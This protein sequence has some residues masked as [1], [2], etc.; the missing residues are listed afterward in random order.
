MY[1]DRPAWA[2]SFQCQKPRV[3]A[4]TS[5]GGAGVEEGELVKPPRPVMPGDWRPSALCSLENRKNL[6]KLEEKK[7][8]TG[9]KSY[10]A[11]F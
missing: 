4:R 11:V 8:F 6:K 3:S 5:G 10:L 2:V 7:V 9:A 1:K